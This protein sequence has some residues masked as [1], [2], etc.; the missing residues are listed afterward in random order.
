MC[1]FVKLKFQ[2]AASSLEHN[3]QCLWFRQHSPLKSNYRLSKL[4]SNR[5]V[6]SKRLEDVESNGLYD[7]DSKDFRIPLDLAKASNILSEVGLFWEAAK[8]DVLEKK[9]YPRHEDKIE[10]TTTTTYPELDYENNKNGNNNHKIPVEE[11]SF[12]SV[13]DDEVLESIEKISEAVNEYFASKDLEDRIELMEQLDA[14]GSAKR[15]K[16]VLYLGGM[17]IQRNRFD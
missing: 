5:I 16:F 8:Y 14:I 12:D 11:A 2:T 3:M 6:A 7:A 9:L 13:S 17:S 1:G 10:E 15:G 4:Y